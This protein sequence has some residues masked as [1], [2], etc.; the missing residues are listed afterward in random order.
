ME[1]KQFSY[2]KNK[3]KVLLLENVHANAEKL[4]SKEEYQVEIHPAGLDEDELCEKI[5]DV[6]IIGIRSK[7]NITRKVLEHANRLHAVGAFCIGTNQID[8]E[9]CQEK[10]VI[11]FNAPFSNTRSVVEL[12]I[13]EMIMLIR[14]LPDKSVA[15]HQGRWEKSASNSNEV[16]GKSL[17]IIGY[18]NIGAQLSVVAEALGMTVY[19]YDVEERLQIGNVI[20]CDTKEELFAKADV[21]TLHVDGRPTNKDIIGEREFSQ[22]KDGVIFIN[23]SRGHVVDIQALKKNVESGKIRGTAVDVFPQ[24]PKSNKEEFTSPLR[25]LP[26]TILTPHIGGST[27]E[28]QENIGSFVP[29]KII[30][31]INTGSSSNSVNFPQVTLPKLIN[32]HRFLHVHSNNPGIIAKINSIM[33]T[34]GINI[35]G[36]YLKTNESIGYVIIDVDKDYDQKVFEDLLAIEGTIRF[37]KLY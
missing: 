16:R 24:E 32:A 15:M 6:S 13:G 9:A 33:A 27:A 4:F 30:D 2:P 19:F 5:K 26:N 7:T 18:G 8:L 22:M 31:Y 36:Q 21:V 14:N 37:R 35:V 23:L 28:A 10:G 12:A 11:V 34:H 25:G 20:K 3:I 29:N 17:G 1:K